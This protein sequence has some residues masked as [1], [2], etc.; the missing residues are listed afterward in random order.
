MFA[1][2]ARIC[3]LI[4]TRA[5]NMFPF[6]DIAMHSEQR[7][8][9]SRIYAELHLLHSKGLGE[10][11]ENILF[12]RLKPL[13]DS[14]ASSKEP[15]EIYETMLSVTMDIVTAFPIRATRFLQFPARCRAEKA[16]TQAISKPLSLR[17]LCAEIA[18]YLVILREARR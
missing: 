18:G 16:A 5:P 14:H 15:R 1:S 8:S 2:L 17:F 13:L 3:E 4:D 9:L 7:R 11:N 10:Q 12:G 6:K